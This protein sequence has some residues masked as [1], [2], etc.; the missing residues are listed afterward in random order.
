M[1]E[2]SLEPYCQH[3]ASIVETIVESSQTAKKNQ[4]SCEKT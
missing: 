2:V 4:S 3:Q 1:L